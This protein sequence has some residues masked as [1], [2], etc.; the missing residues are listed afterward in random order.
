[1][2]AERIRSQVGENT[3]G[4]GK[5]LNRGIGNKITIA[6]LALVPFVNPVIAQETDKAREAE[7]KPVK[8]KGNP[9][10]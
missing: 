1:M 7:A 2:S 3:S 10:P 9:R 6:L 5:G 8:G 4:R